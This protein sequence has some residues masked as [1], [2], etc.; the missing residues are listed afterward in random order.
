MNNTKKKLIEITD[1]EYDRYTEFKNL[2]KTFVYGL[3]LS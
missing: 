3:L 1:Y 2:L